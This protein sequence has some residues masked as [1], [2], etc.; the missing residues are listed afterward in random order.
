[1]TV[2][3][4]LL[5]LPSFGLPSLPELMGEHSLP[6]PSH[7][8]LFQSRLSGNPSVTEATS[9]IHPGWLCLLLVLGGALVAPGIGGSVV[10]QL[11]LV[12]ERKC[13]VHTVRELTEGYRKKRTRKMQWDG[14]PLRAAASAGGGQC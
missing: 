13:T 1:M 7:C 2:S 14:P 8:S 9:R 11:P 10:F 5:L 3:R 4:Q 6:L 12:G